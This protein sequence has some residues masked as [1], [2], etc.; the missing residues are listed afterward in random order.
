MRGDLDLTKIARDTIEC[1]GVR[2][3]RA[4]ISTPSEPQIYIGKDF[5]QTASIAQADGRSRPPK[6]S[7]RNGVLDGNE[8][9]ATR[10]IHQLI[11]LYLLMARAQP[12]DP[13]L[14]AQLIQERLSSR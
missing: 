4:N 10:R 5:A 12:A 8:D 1:V 3:Q 14:G 7:P 9:E 13:P 2:E 6:V 11:A